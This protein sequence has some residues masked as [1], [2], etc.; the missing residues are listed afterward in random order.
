MCL[1]CRLGR[2]VI[3][4]RECLA[5][6][7]GEGWSGDHGTC[8]IDILLSPFILLLTCCSIYCAVLDEAMPA[9]RVA[10]AIISSSILLEQAMTELVIGT[11]NQKEQGR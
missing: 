6:K 1:T 2:C 8:T 4:Q 5:G 9:W 7:R 3:H 11:V 10:S